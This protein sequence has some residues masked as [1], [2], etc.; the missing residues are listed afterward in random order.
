[1]HYEITANAIAVKAYVFAFTL[2]L[3]D[4]Y[5]SETRGV[6]FKVVLG[7]SLWYNLYIMLLLARLFNRLQHQSEVN[8]CGV[9]LWLDV[10]GVR[11]TSFGITLSKATLVHRKNLEYLLLLP[12]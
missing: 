6:P 12:R 7:A 3:L 1:M 2:G 11:R 4:L 8:F 10:S 5:F 9:V